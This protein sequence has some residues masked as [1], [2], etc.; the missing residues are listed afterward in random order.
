MKRTVLL[1]GLLAAA[2]FSA[3][4]AGHYHPAPRYGPRDYTHDHRLDC[5]CRVQC[6]YYRGKHQYR[7]HQDRSS[8]WHRHSIG[9]GR[10]V[11]CHVVKGR[12]F[13]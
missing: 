13:H 7:G 3:G 4:C 11:R 10:Y 1:A 9:Y 6:R 12:H 5:G 8:Y 2:L